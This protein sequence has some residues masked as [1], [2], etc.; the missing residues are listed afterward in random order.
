MTDAKL[1]LHD[2]VQ[3]LSYGENRSGAFIKLR[4]K[5]PEQLAPFRGLDTATMKRAGHILNV[6]ITDRDLEE[7][8]AEIA[9][10]DVQ[11]DDPSTNS[12]RPYSQQA[13][14][15]KLSGFF[16]SPK[17]WPYIGSDDDFAEYIQLHQCIVCGHGDWVEEL[18]EERCEAAHVRRAAEG[19]TGI[20]GDYARVPMCHHDHIDFQHQHGETAAYGAYLAY[21]KAKPDDAV[22]SAIVTTEEAKAWFDKKRLEFVEQWGWETLKKKLGYDSWANTPPNVLREWAVARDLWWALPASYKAASQ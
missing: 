9:A 16:R 8:A 6:V 15:L 17:V 7:V 2:E 19:G 22:L 4:L 1:F 12:T 20:K 21:K 3:L 5:D 10:Q 18:G 14:E 13:K 11:K